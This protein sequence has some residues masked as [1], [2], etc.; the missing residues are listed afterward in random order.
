MA[1]R[2]TPSRSFDHISENTKRILS[3]IR[4][5]REELQ[6][7]SKVVSPK[8]ETKAPVRVDKLPLLDAIATG[9]FE[10]DRLGI[11][12]EADTGESLGRV[13]FLKKI[14]NERGVEED[15][16][17]AYTNDEEDLIHQVATEEYSVLRKYAVASLKDI[18]DKI[19]GEMT[20]LGE[21]STR[22][23]ID[24][25]LR[26][27]HTQY[28]T[29]A[30]NDLITEFGLDEHGWQRRSGGIVP[31]ASDGVDTVPPAKYQEKDYYAIVY[32]CVTVG[33]KSGLYGGKD[34]ASVLDEVRASCGIP[35]AVLRS[36]RGQLLEAVQSAIFDAQNEYMFHTAAGTGKTDLKNIPIADGIKS[37]N[38][39]IDES[40]AIGTAKVT[41]EYTDVDKAL[42]F[43]QNQI[44]PGG[45]G[46]EEAP[47][48]ETETAPEVS[49]GQA[50]PVPPTPQQGQKA[51]GQ[52]QP[53]QQPLIQ[54]A[55]LRPTVE[56]FSKHGQQAVTILHEVYA[57]TDS[58][59]YCN[60]AMEALLRDNS[61]KPITYKCSK[62]GYERDVQVYAYV[63]ENGKKVVLGWKQPLQLGSQ[64]ERPDT[65][66]VARVAGYQTITYSA[67][68]SLVDSLVKE[69]VIDLDEEEFNKSRDKKYYDTSKGIC[70]HCNSAVSTDTSL[71]AK[72]YYTCETCG[73][74]FDPRTDGRKRFDSSDM[75]E[76]SNMFRIDASVKKEAAVHITC[77]KCDHTG[78]EDLFVGGVGDVGVS[79]FER[80]PF[81]KKYT[82]PM[83][84][85][86]FNE[87]DDSTLETGVGTNNN[88]NSLD[89]DNVTKRNNPHHR[90]HRRATLG[91]L[92][93]S[94]YTDDD[95]F[96]GEIPPDCPICSGPG[97]LMG[98]LGRREYFR[99]ENCGMEFSHE[100][101][102]NTGWNTP[103]EF[104]PEDGD[105]VFGS[106]KK[107]GKQ[108]FYCDSCEA[109]FSEGQKSFH[110]G[111]DYHEHDK[112]EGNDVEEGSEGGN[113]KEA[114]LIDR[115]IKEAIDISDE[116]PPMSLQNDES[117]KVPN[118]AGPPLQQQP[119]LAKQNQ[120]PKPGVLYDSSQDSGSQ[121]QTTINPKDKSVT[122]K[123]IDSPEEQALQQA[124]NPQQNPQQQNPQ[125]GQIQFGKPEP[126]PLVS[127][128]NGGKPLGEF[129][130]QDIPTNF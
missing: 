79:L 51:Q 97:A 54:P 50:P 29:R 47:K 102:N 90:F 15:W 21:S 81:A 49:D 119:E 34:P 68:E 61:G 2:K 30:V 101:S 126:P 110:S 26:E 66:E 18:R 124:V 85:M 99:C 107:S 69:A 92:N 83:C 19:A 104:S 39:S 100:N 64:F 43:Y 45:G 13:W 94:G 1:Q 123:F 78:Y 91:L 128:Q 32:D 98:S 88:E 22:T 63:N 75:S 27:A 71:G 62:C 12:K 95:E 58:C 86:R 52:G 108:Y 38:I 109:K 77:P 116:M 121:F 76:P 46:G 127:N 53:V 9:R 56:K 7:E 84:D 106:M 129:G 80:K 125:Q 23:A 96:I 70:P 16:L 41:I 8:P 115:L 93:T 60:I 36:Q 6:K 25:L 105:G 82:C 40:G 117:Q 120:A 57:N 11:Y 111:H 122:V 35:N 113:E 37:K 130:D 48:E 103:D 89:I 31:M 44:G 20:R 87:D 42:D 5:S 67:G 3:N 118:N 24:I 4:Q 10:Y 17:V 28:G 73:I 74:S 14:M 65:T 59:P 112:K 114:S 55:K 72:H 33:A